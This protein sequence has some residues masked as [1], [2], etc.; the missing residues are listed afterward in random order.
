M[1][2][3]MWFWVGDRVESDTGGECLGAPP[4]QRLPTRSCNRYSRACILEMIRLI[5]VCHEEAV[6]PQATQLTETLVGVAMS[7]LG[8]TQ[9]RIS[10][11][12]ADQPFQVAGSSHA[13]KKQTQLTS[14]TT[15]SEK[16]V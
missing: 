11:E 2:N 10:A 7:N 6:P 3:A 9:P 15:S 1:S 12:D 8:R 13:G 4:F 14:C 16:L 5:M